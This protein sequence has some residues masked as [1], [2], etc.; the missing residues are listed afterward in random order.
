MAGRCLSHHLTV[1]CPD[2]L[3]LHPWL[4]QA[5]GAKVRLCTYF[6]LNLRPRVVIFDTVTSSTL[7]LILRW[8]HSM[9]T[10]GNALLLRWPSLRGDYKSVLNILV[11]GVV[12]F[13]SG[14]PPWGVLL[15]LVLAPQPLGVVIFH[16]PCLP[17][18]TAWPGSITLGKWWAVLGSLPSF[19]SYILLSLSHTQNDQGGEVWGVTVQLRALSCPGAECL[20]W[21]GWSR[22]SGQDQRGRD[23]PRTQQEGGEEVQVG[24][25]NL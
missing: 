17:P 2:T 10:C 19:L 15:L 22:S 21:R 5:L 8:N 9:K 11:E 23:V 24:H 3:G 14:V 4:L 1:W 20:P 7:N 13:N 25:V 6:T 12:V 18:S 16:Y